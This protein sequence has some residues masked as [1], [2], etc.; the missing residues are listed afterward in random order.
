MNTTNTSRNAFLALPEKEPLGFEGFFSIAEA[1]QLTLGLTPEVM[2]DKWAICFENDWL[3]FH[4]SWTG[5]LIYAVRL[6][7]S[8]TGAQAVESWVNR[9][10]EEY[11]AC[12]TEYDRKFVRFLID[13]LLLKKPDVI[14][15]MPPNSKRMPKGLL[16]HVLAGTGYPEEAKHGGLLAKWKS[17]CQFIGRRL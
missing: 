13:A 15:P 12:D 5:A 17:L 11:T 1:E 14:F 6:E 10:Q 16:Q 2:E 9:D 7:R 3:Y 4:H 8:P